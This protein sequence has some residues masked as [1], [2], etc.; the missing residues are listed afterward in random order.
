VNACA[1]VRAWSLAFALTF[2]VLGGSGFKV[3]GGLSATCCAKFLGAL[4]G[5]VRAWY[6]WGMLG[7]GHPMHRKTARLWT[8][9]ELAGILGVSVGTVRRLR[10]SFLSD[11]QRSYLRLAGYKPAAYPLRKGKDESGA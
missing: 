5:Y 2:N 6:V 4:L 7:P 1:C 8:D 3:G 10:S 9:E 11:V